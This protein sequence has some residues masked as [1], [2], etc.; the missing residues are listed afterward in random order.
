MSLQLIH[1]KL[2]KTLSFSSAPVQIRGV[3]V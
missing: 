3:F 1:N 2:T